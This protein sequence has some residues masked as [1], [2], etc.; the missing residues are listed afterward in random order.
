M[1]SVDEDPNVEDLQVFFLFDNL[2]SLSFFFG[3]F[4]N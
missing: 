4:A 1:A 2:L 3:I